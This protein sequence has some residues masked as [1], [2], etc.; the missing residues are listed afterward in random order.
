MVTFSMAMLVSADLPRSRDF[1]RDVLGLKVRND[2]PGW[3]D[4]D[5][6]GGAALGLH[7]PTDEMPI[8]PGSLQLGFEVDDVDAFIEDARAKGAS[9]VMEPFDES[10][11]RLSLILDPDG[12]TVQVYTPRR[13]S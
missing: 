10:F 4:F 6:G 5:L 11:G 8:R 1:Y 13:R 12:Y 9:I 3:V 2:V 7:P